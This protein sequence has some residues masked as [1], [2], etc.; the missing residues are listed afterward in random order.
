MLVTDL[1]LIARVINDIIEDLA[2]IHIL[3]SCVEQTSKEELQ[4]LS[5]LYTQLD[6]LNL[7]LVVLAFLS[8]TISDLRSE[9]FV[10]HVRQEEEGLD[11]RVEVACVSDVFEADRQPILPLSLV[12]RQRFGLHTLKLSQI[13]VIVNLLIGCVLAVR[14]VCATTMR[15]LGLRGVLC[16]KVQ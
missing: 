3:L 7:L 12:Q 13:Q 11:E 2:R 15:G 1:L 9:E 14:L 16:L 8:P 5:H 10:S 4:L 6:S